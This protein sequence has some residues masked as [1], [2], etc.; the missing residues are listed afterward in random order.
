MC[1]A[2]MSA[3]RGLKKNCRLFVTCRYNDLTVTGAATAARLGNN[4]AGLASATDSV[5]R[6]F[7]TA[8]ATHLNVVRIFA[9][10]GESGDALEPSPGGLLCR[11]SNPAAGGNRVLLYEAHNDDHYSARQS[12][13]P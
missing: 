2:G 13:H 9:S 7:A 11:C 12:S 1:N 10:Q 3:S 4:T 8:D 6:R 5:T